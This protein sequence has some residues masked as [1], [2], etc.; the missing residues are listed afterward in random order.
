MLRS[1]GYTGD[2]L[3][4]PESIRSDRGSAAR[5]VKPPKERLASLPGVEVYVP[6][7]DTLDEICGWLG[8]FRERLHRA[9]D[10]ER[11][12]MAAVIQQ[13]EARYQNRRAELS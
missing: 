13:L 4:A 3:T 5:G 10:E 7:I 1:A 6:H 12:Q 8:T 2:E 9:R 11:P